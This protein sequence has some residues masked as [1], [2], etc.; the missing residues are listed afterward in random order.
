M[1]TEHPHG[2]QALATTG[3][4]LDEAQAAMILVHGRGASGQSILS[5][6]NALQQ[7]GFAYLAPQAANNTWYPYRFIEPIK[8]N[9]PF[10]SSGLRVLSDLVIQIEQKG[11]GVDNIVF[12]GFSQGACLAAEFVARN[13]K[14]YGGLLVFSGGLIGLEGKTFGYEGSLDGTPVFIGCSAVDFHI[15]VQRVHET[16]DVLAAMGAQV[17]KQIYPNMGHTIIEDELERAR[18]IVAGVLG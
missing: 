1:M 5:L 14:R 6:A 10:L 9:Q 18:K 11:I 12:A 3:K 15:P 4:S 8:R 16:A 13:P 7:P 2:N 17:E